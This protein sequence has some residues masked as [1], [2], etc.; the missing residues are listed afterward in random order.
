LTTSVEAA[1]SRLSITM[2][3]GSIRLSSVV[4]KARAILYDWRAVGNWEQASTGPSQSLAALWDFRG[5]FGH[6]GGPRFLLPPFGAED[7]WRG[8]TMGSP[9]R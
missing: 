8:P 1:F 3:V 9:L 6:C 7:I 2:S 5:V 4:E